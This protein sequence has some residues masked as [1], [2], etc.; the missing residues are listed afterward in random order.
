M[1]STSQSYLDHHYLHQRL[2][3][4][5]NAITEDVED[6]VGDRNSRRR[7]FCKSKSN[8]DVLSGFRSRSSSFGGTT[9]SK[10]SS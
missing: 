5:Q 3:E 9:N 1:P 8:V 7:F 6:F 2:P 4:R 10:V